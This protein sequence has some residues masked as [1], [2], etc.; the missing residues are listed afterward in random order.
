MFLNLK[1]SSR[2]PVLIAIMEEL[3]LFA[4]SSCLLPCMAILTAPTD[5]GFMATS[6]YTSGSSLFCWLA[7]SGNSLEVG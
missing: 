3:F 7:I 4:H 1:S 6:D 5:L 2:K